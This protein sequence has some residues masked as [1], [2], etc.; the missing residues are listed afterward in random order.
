ALTEAISLDQFPSLGAGLILVLLVCHFIVVACP[1]RSSSPRRL[2]PAV[3][4]ARAVDTAPRTRL[5]CATSAYPLQPFVPELNHSVIL[6]LL[7]PL[8]RFHYH[9]LPARSPSPLR[10]LIVVCFA[11]T[12]DTMP[13]APLSYTTSAYPP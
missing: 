10:L 7:L 11:H 2:P 12:V 8:H 3:F 6:V 4:F 5:P 1:A 13:C 9:G